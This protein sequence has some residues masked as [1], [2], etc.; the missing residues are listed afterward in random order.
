MDLITNQYVTLFCKEHNL[1]ES[2]EEFKKFEHF[3]AYVVFRREYSGTID[4][5]DVLTG[6][7][8]AT[9][10]SGGS[11]TGID[12]IGIVVNDA[13][14]TDLDELNEQLGRP[15]KL[16]VTFIF[17]QSEI[18]AHFDSSKIGTFGT[19][20]NDFFAPS[21]TL[22]RSRR[23]SEFAA[24]RKAIYDQA[25][26]FKT[27]NPLCK[28]FYV[29]TGTWN[30]D[31]HPKAARDRARLALFDTGLFSQVLFEPIGAT[32][33][34]DLYRRTQS[35]I[36]TQFEFRARVTVQPRIADVSSAY[37]GFLPWS[38]FKK[39][40][41]DASGNLMRGL[42]FDNVRDFQGWNKVNNEI[43]E[44]LKGKDRDRF[45]LMNNGLT[46]ITRTLNT[47]A[48]QFYMEDYQIVNGCQTS[49]VLFEERISLE[50]Q[51][52]TIPIRLIHT[53]DE[54]IINS[55]VKA[56]NWQTAVTEQ[57]LY[58]LQEFPRELEAFFAAFHE[59]ERM[60]YERRSGQYDHLTIERTRIINSTNTIRAYAA[61]FLAEPHRTIRNYASIWGKVSTS[62]F[63][64]G[65]KMD[66]YH[67]AAFSYY[68]LD[69]MLRSK[70]LDPKHKLARFQILLAFRYAASTD[71]PPGPKNRK[72]E[73]Y[74]KKIRAVLTDSTRCEA[75]FL[76][77][78]QVVSDL[79][80]GDFDRDTIHSPAFTRKIIEAFGSTGE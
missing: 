50:A 4:T 41:M 1:P 8:A 46:I 69:A 36:K 27:H 20:V 43:S 11:D 15:G 40:I 21:P 52:V 34:Q 49:N 2:L 66:A 23:I 12:A 14:V 64:K 39:I 13:L 62:I 47:V 67:V 33:L 37:L 31:A 60:Y 51:Q 72:M 65:H 78:A 58:A 9:S 80:A 18:S 76:R 32:A 70:R 53:T 74:C 7:E 30:E 5:H 38:E 16:D 57:Q 75:T 73:G 79:L 44:T 26:R 17:I 63:V 61:M 56:A 10:Y 68:K 54:T 35:T 42:F 59:T 71:T 29:T 77:A 6:D 48:D 55:I 19:G 24:M 22:P 3:A 28:L 45:V 25:V